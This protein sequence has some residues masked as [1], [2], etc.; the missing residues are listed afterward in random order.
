MESESSD[1]ANVPP[2]LDLVHDEGID[3]A[4]VEDSFLE[5]HFPIGFTP[6][7]SDKISFFIRGTE[8]WIDFSQ[9]FIEIKGDILGSSD[10]YVAGS[11]GPKKSGKADAEFFLEQNFWHSIFSSI[12]IDVNDTS[13]SINN[14]NYPYA[15]YF[16]NLLNLTSD[17]QKTVGALCYW[18]T[19]DERKNVYMNTNTSI[20]GIIQIKSPLFMKLKNLLPFVNVAVNMNRV[21]KPAFFFRWGSSTSGYSFKITQIVFRIRKV[22]VKDTWNE[23]YEQLMQAGKLIRYNFQDFRVFTRTYSGFG[24]DIIE[25][26]LFHGA[27]PEMVILGFVENEAFSG[28]KS[29]NPFNFEHFTGAISEIG[30]FV[31]GQPFPTPM[32]KMDFGK[33]DT[34]QAYHLLMASLGTLNT[35]DPPMITKADFDSGGS[36]LFGFNLSPDQYSGVDPKT[37]YNQPANIRLHV[38]F[39]TPDAT[40][41]VTLIVYYEMHSVMAINKTRQV[42]FQAR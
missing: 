16:Q 34:F 1:F 10:D 4:F 25:D 28:T 36:T 12:D 23:F 26:N 8:H 24:S 11:S 35:P 22:K 14:T 17:Q 21:A 20:G 42:M 13:I 38:K 2:Q 29:K 33:K 9:S 27:K 41:N 31:N 32:I 40:R 6:S 7:T 15:A 37:I 5:D 3:V 39:A 18:G 19:D 30:L